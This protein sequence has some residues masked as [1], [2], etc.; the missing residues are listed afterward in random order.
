[1]IRRPLSDSVGF[2]PSR[3]ALALAF[4]ATVLSCLAWTATAPARETPPNIVLVLADDLG[5]AELGSYGNRFNETP[6][7]DRMAREGI[8]FTQAYA[9]APVCSPD[10][11]ALMAGLHPARVGITDYLRP[12][13]PKHL[14]PEV[15]TIAERLQGAGYATGMIGKWH[16]TGYEHHGAAEIGPGKQGFAEVL[17][18]ERRGIGGGSY[19]HPYHFNP[20]IKPRRE[21]EYLVDRM[22]LEAAEFIECHKD[23]PFFLYVSHYA[24]H[25]RLAGKP[26][27]VAR[28]EKKPGAGNGHRAKRNNPHLAAQ[29]E[30]IDAGM[31]LILQKL[32]ELGL[33]R[34]TLVVFMSDNGGEARVTSNAP[35][36]G[37]KS[38]LYE[39]GIRVPLLV[40]MP[41]KV[42]PGKVCEEPV[43]AFDLYPT[44][45]DAAGLK[46]VEEEPLDGVSLVPVLKDPKAGLDRKA[47]HWHYPLKR[48]HFLGGTSSGAIRQGDWKLIEHF[49]TGQVELFDLA[50][51]PGEKQ[52]LARAMP[53]KARELRDAL[54]AWRD[55]VGA[56]APS[57][58]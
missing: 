32:V 48:P 39:G 24:V 13:D 47:L 22:N 2:Q 42:P 15:V 45:L 50:R 26:D 20:A 8:R 19:F 49:D 7:L 35:L 34:R 43:C 55:G 53:E 51:D 31:G 52:D 23:G 6:H 12:D 11:V 16:L 14:E 46:P 54:E 27:L 29:L 25:T 18:S 38:M 28:Y 30:S 40:R 37:G 21:N 4:C 57:P 17:V 36:R 3:G 10:R 58:P 41:G 9:A 5:W 33:D 44:F 56:A 1:M